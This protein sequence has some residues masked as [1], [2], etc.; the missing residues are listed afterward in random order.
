MRPQDAMM[1]PLIASC[2]LFGLYILFH[3]GFL[4]LRSWIFKSLSAATTT[5][6]LKMHAHR[7]RNQLIF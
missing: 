7:L 5:Y 1:F 3:V 4:V 2:A 6:L